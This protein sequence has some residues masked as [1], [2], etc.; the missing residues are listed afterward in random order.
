MPW[1]VGP[2]GV[3][4][5]FGDGFSVGG[6]DPDVAVVDEHEDVLS[7]VGSSDGEVVE[8]SGVAQG[9]CA[10]LVDAVA[11][12]AE[13]A[14][15]ADRCSC[16]LGFDACGVRG[17][18]GCSVFGAVGAYVVVVGGEDVELGLELCE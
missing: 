11:S 8:F 4:V 2:A 14:G 17:A 5:V 3:D 7:S 16:G 15:V 1:L 9:D 6:E 18:G 13:L 12:D 10:G